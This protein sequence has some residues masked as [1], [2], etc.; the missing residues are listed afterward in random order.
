MKESPDVLSHFGVTEEIGLSPEQ[1]KKN[2]DKYGYNG[3]GDTEAW[4]DGWVE[5]WKV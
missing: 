4:L 5:R 3:E 2:L 1:F